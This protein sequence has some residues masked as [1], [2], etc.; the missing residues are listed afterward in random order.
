MKCHIEQS[1]FCLFSKSLPDFYFYK[2][3]TRSNA[4]VGLDSTF[5]YIFGNNSI[6]F[7]IE[8]Y[9]IWIAMHL[10]WI[11]LMYQV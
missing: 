8:K 11:G 2:E 7:A 9:Y 4:K 10:S 3:S 5:S 1:D 6:P